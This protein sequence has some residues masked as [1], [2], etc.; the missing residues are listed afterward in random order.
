MDVVFQQFASKS[1]GSSGA[2]AAAVLHVCLVCRTLLPL[3]IV[4]VLHL[5]NGL[6]PCTHN[7]CST[8]T[9]WYIWQRI[10]C[11]V[12]L[13]TP[14]PACG[15]RCESAGLMQVQSRGPLCR[16]QQKRQQQW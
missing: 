8:M 13:A 16:Q 4:Y 3:S 5:T 6:P 15:T 10:L 2:L 7:S 11:Y 9:V 14:V 12:I 1:C